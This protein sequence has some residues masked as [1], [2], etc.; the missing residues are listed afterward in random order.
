M[1]ALNLIRYPSVLDI[2]I[3]QSLLPLEREVS[4][5]EQPGGQACVILMDRS[6]KACGCVTYP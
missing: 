1:N 4:T 5:S 2:Q 3:I 6:L